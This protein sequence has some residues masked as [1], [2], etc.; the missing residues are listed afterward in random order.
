MA[1]PLKY[2]LPVVLWM[3]LIFIMSTSAGSATH[4]GRILAYLMGFLWPQAPQPTVELIQFL[5][6]KAGHFS[7]Y[8][9][10]AWLLCRSWSAVGPLTITQSR[11]KSA[12]AAILIAMLYA[13]SDEWHQSF[14]PGRSAAVRDVLL[15]STGALTAAIAWLLSQGRNKP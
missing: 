13:G 4:T 15:D 11:W 7:E 14:V 12:L 10:L 5:I 6:R 1:N 2:W 3:G 8:A 9:V